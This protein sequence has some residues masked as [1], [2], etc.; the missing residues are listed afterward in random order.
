M[1]GFY[2]WAPVAILATGAL[3]TVGV[4]TQK[5][6]PLRAPLDSTVPAVL[7]GYSA[8]D[9]VISEEEQRV[10][11]MTNYLMRVYEPEGGAVDEVA[12]A[13]GAGAF[14]V[15]VGYYESQTQGK[16]IHSP[17]NCLPGA[18]WE[19]LTSQAAT[20]TTAAGAVAVNRFLLQNEDQR[21]LVLYWYQGRGRIESNEY[22]VKLDL[23][24]DSALKGRSDEALVRVIVPV[25]TSE[26]DA[27]RMAEA[28]AQDLIPAVDR[29]IPS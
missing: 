28:V 4:D 1:T 19:A 29:A 9:I 23:L 17:K 2:R 14:S 20:I 10:A 25:T 3:F 27:F 26:E 15:Y 18:G 5:V 16:T 6:M 21:A 7:Q 13:T 11:G 12:A 8:K 22:Q 24:R